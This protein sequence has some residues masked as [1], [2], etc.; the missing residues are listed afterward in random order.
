MTTTVTT[1]GST[2]KVSTFEAV[3][4]EPV[5]GFSSNSH[6]YTGLGGGGGLI[7]FWSL[8]QYFQGHNSTL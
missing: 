7:K 6:R 1:C 5:G 8:W 4:Y 2:V 3:S